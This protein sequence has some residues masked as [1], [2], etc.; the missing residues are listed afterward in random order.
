MAAQDF[1]SKVENQR[2][3]FSSGV[4][5]EVSFRK[6]MLKRLDLMIK[7][8]ASFIEEALKADLGKSPMEAYAAEVASVRSEIR[9]AEKNLRKWVRPEPRKTSFFNLPGKSFIYPEPYGTV[10]IIA[11]WDYPFY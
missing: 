1:L 6:S 4:T 5:L 8:N 7:E 3:Y 2:N 10:L 9:Y 11:P